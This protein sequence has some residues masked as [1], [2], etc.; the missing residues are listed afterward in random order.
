MLIHD[1]SNN[2]LRDLQR[3]HKELE[4]VRDKAKE[5]LYTVEPII[6]PFTTLQQAQ[7][8]NDGYY[9]HQIEELRKQFD[10]KHKS[11]LK[12]PVYVAI[13]DT[14][15][16]FD[17]ET[18]QGTHANEHGE[19]FTNEQKLEDGHGHGHGC[20]TIVAGI[21]NDSR[22]IGVGPHLEGMVKVIPIKALHNRGYALGSWL[23]DAHEY[24]LDL[25]E[26][27]L[28]K[29]G[30][31]LYVSGSFS[32]PNPIKGM[33]E[34][35]QKMVDAGI[36]L[37]YSAGN[38]GYREGESTI[39]YPAAN[40]V[41]F[42][43]GSIQK[44]GQ[45]SGFSSAGPEIDF[46]FIGSSVF[47]GW[48]DNAYVFWSGTSASRPMEAGYDAWYLA[49]YPDEIKTQQDLYEYKQKHAIDLMTNGF[50]ERT[51][52]GTMKGTNPPPEGKPEDPG[53]EPPK[54]TRPKYI[55]ETV[56]KTRKGNTGQYKAGDP[57]ITFKG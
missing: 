33:K 5:P 35:N 30:A 27:K 14:A 22:Q 31:A 45:A 39:G 44:N 46:T 10:G 38:S 43:T 8:G 57:I 26:K 32:G 34:L 23:I 2:Q 13:V 7:E 50:D 52:L 36:F 29:E 28:K 20:A 42:A 41:G 49:A 9:Y 3:T 1:Q 11:K 19:L 48:K 37:G 47:S 18:L 51:G 21:P 53:P 4:E 25:W 40:N 55:I 17:H 54:E 16:V 6:N 15:G 24:L 12:R 56:V